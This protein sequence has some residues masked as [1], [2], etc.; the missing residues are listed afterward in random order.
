[1]TERSEP[2]V[3]DVDT[4]IDDAFALLYACAHRQA[5][6]LGVST[7]VGNVSLAAATR[8]TRAVLALA[9][10]GDIPVWPGAGTAISIAAR[11]A[12]EIHGATGL[13]HAVLPDP[14]EPS[15]A[16]HAADM[17][18]DAARAHS[19]RLVLCAVGPLTNIAL[20]V[21]RE[22]ELPR[23]LKRFVIM[24]GAYSDSG[25]VTPAAE[26]NIWHDA[27]A[28]RIVF[29]AFGA[30]GGAPV[31]A[32]GLDVTRKTTI[33]ER[34]I[35]TIESRIAGKPRGPK[36]TRFL[37][38]ASRFYFERM[39]KTLGK[40]IFTMH[41]PLAVAVALDPT[42]VET[43]SATVDIET[44]GRLTTGATIVDWRGQWG[45]LANAEVAV[46][47]DAE[48]FRSLFFEAIGRLAD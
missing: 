26:F 10:R 48:R 36:L 35:K 8:N 16:L 20:A 29:R 28:A 47:V 14:E 6:I 41:D 34:D 4:G 38:D 25:N 46:A 5:H 24:G 21:M 13:G 3:L 27:E 33:D 1:M 7:V 30:P 11:D 23:L 42:L 2:L 45:R 43:R 32:I 22:P 31:I 39:E 15:D 9:G 18:I 40:R 17:I 12:S 44:T 37:D 19:G